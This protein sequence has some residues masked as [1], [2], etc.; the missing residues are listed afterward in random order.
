LT[1]LSPIRK[2]PGGLFVVTREDT[3]R[4][5]TKNAGVRQYP[6]ITFYGYSRLSLRRGVLR[7]ATNYRGLALFEALRDWTVAMH[8]ISGLQRFQY[9]FLQ[10]VGWRPS[11]REVELQVLRER[12]AKLQAEFDRRLD[13]T[14]AEFDRRLVEARAE[15]DGARAAALGRGVA[16]AAGP[17]RRGGDDA[18]GTS[19]TWD[20][21]LGD[22]ARAAEAAEIA[23]ATEQRGAESSSP[24]SAADGSRSG[25]DAAPVAA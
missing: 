12:D 9:R 17:A 1:P 15:I 25:Q 11:D 16:S 18:G 5:D 4:S 3:T 2:A 10:A 8:W 6:T 19:T 24:L 7:R 13:E 23:G 20:D 21:I 14:R 22:L